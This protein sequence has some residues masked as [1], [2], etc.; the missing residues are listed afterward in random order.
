MDIKKLVDNMSI[1][2]LCGQ[3]LSYDIQPGERKKNWY[4]F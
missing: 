4:N 1:E 2:E 3:V